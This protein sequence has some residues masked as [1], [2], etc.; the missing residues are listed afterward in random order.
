MTKRAAVQS[1]ITHLQSLITLVHMYTW[2][3]HGYSKD[4]IKCYIENHVSPHGYIR[5]AF[6]TGYAD[7]N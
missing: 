4:D 7:F 5:K 1:N 2:M 3:L 6:N